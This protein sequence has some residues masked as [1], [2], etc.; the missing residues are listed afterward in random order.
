[1]TSVFAARATIVA[2]AV[3]LLALIALHI[4]KPDLHPSRTM[5]SR[6]ALGPYGWMMALCFAAFGVGSGS[7]AVAIGAS[8][9]LAWRSIRNRV[10]ADSCRRV[11]D[12]GAL[13]Y[14]SRKHPACTDVALRTDARRGVPAWCAEY[15]ARGRCPAVGPQR[16]AFLSVAA[17]DDRR[18]RLDQ[19]HRHAR[20]HAQGWSRKAA[21]SEW[22]GSTCGPAEPVAHGGVCRV[23]DDRGMARCSL[24][25]RC[26]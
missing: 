5:I 23:V 26:A 11:C 9:A 21:G 16:S 6:Y 14:G 22:T 2:A 15:G 1:M 18:C 4:L 12:G 20:H 10:T 25:T 19:P 7:L 17:D 24:V 8:R 13:S 3:S